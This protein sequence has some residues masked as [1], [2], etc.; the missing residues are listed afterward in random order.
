MMKRP[1]P[2]RLLQYGR[3]YFGTSFRPDRL[4]PLKG[5]A[6]TRRY[7]RYREPD[8]SCIL[9]LYPEAEDPQIEEFLSIQSLLRS[10]A[11]AVPEVLA[12]DR[13]LGIVVQ[14]DLGNLTLEQRILDTSTEACMDH[15]LE[16]VRQIVVIQCEAS[17]R[18]SVGEPAFERAFD[19][20]KLIWEL[21]YFEEHYLKGLRG[22]SPSRTSC[23]LGEFDDLAHRISRYAR[24]LCHRDLQV[25]NLMIHAGR[26]YL[27]D[28]QDARQG[29]LAYDLVSLTQDSICLTPPQVQRLVEAYRSRIP[30]GW[31]DSD[32]QYQ[33]H[34]I[35]I[36]R[37]L[38]ALGTYGFQI[39]KRRNDSYTTYIPGTLRRL[40]PALQA[41]CEFPYIR[42]LVE[43]ESQRLDLG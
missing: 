35:C 38:K 41:V 15:L 39:G 31:A 24:K 30:P 28:F 23:L 43:E 3:S 5:D 37:L 10:C 2:R 16:A 40:L 27:I 17:A 18:L 13:S 25:R 4:Q 22:L 11:L 20:Q 21:H 26:V 34:L 1:I 7:F 12:T 9:A 14:E 36:Q 42:S 6:S 19:H 32:F 8:S 29:P 33:F